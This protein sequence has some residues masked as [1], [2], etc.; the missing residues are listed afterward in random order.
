MSSISFTSDRLLLRNLQ[1]S[2]SVNFAQLAGDAD[3]MSPIPLQI[4]SPQESEVHLAEVLDNKDII[5]LAITLKVTN[6]FIGFCAVYKDNEILYR[7]K[8]QHWKKGFGTEVASA[9]ID[10]CFTTLKMEYVTAEANKTNIASLKILSK[11]M[12][13][14]SEYFNE[15]LNCTNITFSS[16]Y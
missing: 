13:E 11:F 15:E 2:D 6:E 14:T 3:V 8:P 1:L 7:L 9:I 10:Y 16:N 4:M 12:M 5:A